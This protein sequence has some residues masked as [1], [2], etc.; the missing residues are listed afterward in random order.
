MANLSHACLRTDKAVAC[1]HAQAIKVIYAV[2][3]WNIKPSAQLAMRYKSQGKPGP[4]PHFTGEL[5]AAF[6][7]LVLDASLVGHKILDVNDH[8]RVSQHAT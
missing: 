4:C 1:S 6:T 7:V 5:S 2:P 8:V 3:Q